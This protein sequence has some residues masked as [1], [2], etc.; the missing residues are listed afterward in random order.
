MAQLLEQLLHV[1]HFHEAWETPSP[2]A[3]LPRAA[4]LCP[5]PRPPEKRAEID[6]GILN[7]NPILVKEIIARIARP[8]G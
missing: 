2:R 1:E 8:N 4:I 7:P 3:P 5:R 6:R